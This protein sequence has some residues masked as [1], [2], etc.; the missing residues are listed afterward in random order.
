MGQGYNSCINLNNWAHLFDPNSPEAQQGALN[1]FDAW[2]R[3]GGTVQ[4]EVSDTNRPMY[5]RKDASGKSV[6]RW[7]YAD[8][9]KAV[10]ES[11]RTAF[12]CPIHCGDDIKEVYSKTS[13]FS[14]SKGPTVFDENGAQISGLE[15]FAPEEE[16]EPTTVE[17]EAR[18]STLKFF[19]VIVVVAV[20]VIY[21][22][23]K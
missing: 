2:A 20:L 12:P 8:T 22:V 18:K 5:L 17:S 15:R 1:C 10:P 19:A 14:K 7:T 23:T 21:K 9:G 16:P 13:I 6:G 3:T 4:A 11:D